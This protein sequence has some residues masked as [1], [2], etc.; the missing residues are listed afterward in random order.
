MAPKGNTFCVLQ[1]DERQLA[2]LRVRRGDKGVEVTE[3]FQETGDWR[4]ET[5]LGEALR[6]FA[7][8]HRLG[9]EPLYTV[10]PRYEMTARLLT[11][12][13]HELSEIEGMVRLNAGEY[14]PYRPEDLIVD[15]C[16]LARL[17][18]GESR[19]LA[20]FA[21]RDV[22]ER[23]VRLLRDAGL[24]P[25]EIHVSTPALASTVL[26]TREDNGRGLALVHLSPGGIEILVTGPRAIE[27]GR[28]VALGPGMSLEEGRLDEIIEE[29]A[30]E[31]RASL[32]AYRREADAEEEI[33]CVYVASEVFNP[34]HLCE[35]LTSRLGMACE[36]APFARDLAGPNV[37]HTTPLAVLGAALTAQGRAPLVVNLVPESMVAR[38]AAQ[39]FRRSLTKVLLVM[40]AILLASGLC[41]GQ[42]V[43][44][45]LAYIGEISTQA[46]EL[47]PS[48]SNVLEKRRQLRVLQRQVNPA[49]SALEV[50]ANVMRVAPESGLNVTQFI[51]RRGTELLVQGRAKSV[52]EVDAFSSA[53][54]DQGGPLFAQ[55][56]RGPL[57]SVLEANGQPVEEY[58]IKVPWP[59]DATEPD[60]EEV[61]ESE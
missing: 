10:L 41:Y 17:P 26:A 45:R 53:L 33:A 47:R 12:P 27:Y 43:R 19:V 51:Y 9:E 28:G 15:E 36:P 40:A 55:A 18:S 39:D 5:E 61:A 11:L 24:E 8:A 22:V 56:R 46:A 50:L 60:A 16:V 1:F 48:A 59:A 2:A 58:Q 35:K 14:V 30:S 25:Q 34:R 32:S 23:H 52:E 38:R 37:R 44:L 21:H 6:A 31:V 13:S 4:S 42:A 57:K 29:L 54:R 7:T 20:V 3:A 49:G